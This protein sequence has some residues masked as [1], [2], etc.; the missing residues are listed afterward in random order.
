VDGTYRMVE[1]QFEPAAG[2]EVNIGV[3]ALRAGF[4]GG[5]SREITAGTGFYAG[6]GALDYSFGVTAGDLNASH[7]ISYSFRFGGKPSIAAQLAAARP[8]ATQAVRIPMAM[9]GAAASVD[10]SLASKAP[11]GAGP[12]LSRAP[13]EI[14]GTGV[15]RRA[16]RTYQIKEGESLASIARDQY[17]DPRLWRSI[18]QANSH[19]IDDPTS[20]KAGTKIVLP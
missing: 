12:V 2:I 6:R 20:V 4:R 7:R 13:V 15:T 19:L 9:P 3:L 5:P 11:A 8:A 1:K 16:P 10:K 18:Y 14:T 17:G